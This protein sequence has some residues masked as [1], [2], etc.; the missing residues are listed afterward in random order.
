M[1]S[2]VLD[3][4]RAYREISSLESRL[5]EEHRNPSAERSR[6]RQNVRGVESERENLH[7][8]RASEVG[9]GTGAVAGG[10]ATAAALAKESGV[11]HAYWLKLAQNHR[12]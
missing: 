4:K 5:Q 9:V 6:T 7:N 3:L 1:N 8:F 2:Y 10:P 11:D 12:Q